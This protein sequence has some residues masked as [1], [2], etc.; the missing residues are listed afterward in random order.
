MHV[1]YY[2]QFG[3]RVR[4]GTTRNLTAELA[5]TPYERILGTE[6]G[7]RKKAIERYQQFQDYHV[8]GE[9]FAAVPET[10][11]AI[12]EIVSTP[13]ARTPSWACEQ[14][15]CVHCG[16]EMAVETPAPVPFDTGLSP[17]ESFL[18]DLISAFPDGARVPSALLHEKYAEWC[19]EQ[20]QPP[21][22]PDAVSR[23]AIKIGY[24]RYRTSKERGFIAG[25]AGSLRLVGIQEEE[26]MPIRK[27][28]S[29]EITQRDDN[30]AGEAAAQPSSSQL[31]RQAAMEAPG[32]V[33]AD[34][35]WTPDD[36]AELWREDTEG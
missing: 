1:I 30:A 18:R 23:I 33:P 10:L 28:G 29:G 5:R 9:W 35:N 20:Q 27:Q 8:T 15:V 36:E 19:K 25:T 7:A 32:V 16:T 31:R 3:N 26:G 11:A 13:S 34:Q 14:H 24:T 2:L 4:I 22:S 6:P 12:R 21:A 17:G